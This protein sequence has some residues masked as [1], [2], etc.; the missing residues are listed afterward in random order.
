MFFGKAELGHHIEIGL[1][2][3][4]IG[5]ALRIAIGIRLGERPFELLGRKRSDLRRRAGEMDEIEN[6]GFS[7]WRSTSGF[8]GISGKIIFGTTSQPAWIVTGSAFAIPLAPS[9]NAAT[10][11]A[12]RNRLTR[13]APSPLN[14]ALRTRGD[15]AV[16]VFFG[17]PQQIA[18]VI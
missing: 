4:H 8:I 16:V 10:R 17:E 18:A 3:L 2:R 5:Q 9:N 15:L 7:V 12:A 13:I 14:R 1:Q 6:V 11:L